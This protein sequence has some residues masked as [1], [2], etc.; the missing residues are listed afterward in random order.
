MDYLKS[1]MTKAL[2]DDEDDKSAVDE[3]AQASSEAATSYPFTAAATFYTS[4]IASRKY[5][6]YQSNVQQ[7]LPYTEINLPVSRWKHGQHI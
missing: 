6:S 2:F 7:Q 5:L 4:C 3:D 1:R